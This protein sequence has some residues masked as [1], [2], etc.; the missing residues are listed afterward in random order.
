MEV[1]CGRGCCGRGEGSCLMVLECL[2]CSSEDDSMGM[3]E[4]PWLGVKGLVGA[5]GS[6][7]LAMSDWL[8]C[9]I[10]SLVPPL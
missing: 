4:P 8:H 7:G 10:Q 5:V 9:P 3:S 2:G 1:G 6:L